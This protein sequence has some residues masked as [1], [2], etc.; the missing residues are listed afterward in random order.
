M[1]AVERSARFLKA[2]RESCAAKGFNNVRFQEADLMAAEIDAENFDAAWCRW[3]AS[4][5]ASPRILIEKIA[6]ALRPG[7]VAIF[8]E[9]VAYET[10]RL[11]P[12]RLAMEEFVRKVMESWRAA[13]G[14]ANIALELPGLL[15]AAGLEI[16]HAAPR[17]FAVR[18]GE[19][20]WEWPSSFLEVNLQRLADLGRATPE[21]CEEARIDF[22]AAT[23]DPSTILT[24]P[25]VLEIIAKRG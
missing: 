7:G 21:W 9:Y 6:K 12:R 22:E 16:I 1:L 14:E 8:H 11:A 23:K 4:F 19:P 10:F 17:V 25:M 18:P 15:R 20:M 3:V 5:V 13:G 24:T 2:A